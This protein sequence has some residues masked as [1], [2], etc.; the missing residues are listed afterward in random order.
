MHAA[1]MEKAVRRFLS[2]GTLAQ[3]GDF[4][5]R[6]DIQSAGFSNGFHCVCRRPSQP[7]RP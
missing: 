1:I 4:H 5:V 7:D 6:I 3:K 2:I